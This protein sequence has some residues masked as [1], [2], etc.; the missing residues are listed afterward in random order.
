M[1]LS[2]IWNVK[3]WVNLNRPFQGSGEVLYNMGIYQTSY[4]ERLSL[5]YSCV[6]PEEARRKVG[7]ELTSEIWF[8]YTHE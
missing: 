4:S 2:S 7:A 1:L 5:H 8:V 3:F 6:N